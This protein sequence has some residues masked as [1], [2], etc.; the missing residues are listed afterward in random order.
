MTAEARVIRLLMELRRAGVTDTRVL[1]AIERIPRELFVPEPFRDQAY[2]NVAL[3]IGYGQTLS[4]PVVVA[5]MSQALD[6]GDRMKVLEVGTGSGYQTAVLS[7]LA[8]R[9]Y[10]VERN[11]QL[12]HG[13]EKRF[14]KLRLYN[15]TSRIGDGAEGWVEQAPFDRILVTAAAEEIPETLVEQIKVGGSM[16]I[17]VGPVPG[18][19]T[20]TRVRRSEGGVTTESLW[21]VRFVP[22]TNGRPA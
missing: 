18:E 10:T 8:R 22:L 21:T 5:R 15:L 2:E 20:V 1:A 17:P 11:R 13:A 14:A 9:V 3:P 7:H 4:Q 6:V 12:L 16:V 19:Q